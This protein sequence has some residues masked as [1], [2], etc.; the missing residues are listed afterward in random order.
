M[1]SL[2]NLNKSK[3]RYIAIKNYPEN[4]DVIVE[5][6]YTKSS[7]SRTF[8]HS[9]I[10]D[11]RSI[12]V[13]IQHSLI[14]VPENDFEPR[15]DD[16]RVGY[17][18][19]QI[20]DMTSPHSTPYRDLIRRWH[21]KKKNPTAALSEPVEPIIWWIENTTPIEFR[22][23]IKQGVYNGIRPSKRRGSKTRWSS[24]H[25]LILPLGMPAIFA[26]MFYA[27]PLHQYRLMGVMDHPLPTQ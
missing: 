16:P 21:L 1:P 14:A 26:I 3:S 17:F 6:V 5:Y 12:S 18:A 22:K 15:Y 27:G 23:V 7:N 11:Q 25:N 10:P 8:R 13:H 24:K 4:T 20:T 19:D 2:G 9:S